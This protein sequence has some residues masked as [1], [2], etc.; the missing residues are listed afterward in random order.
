MNSYQMTTTGSSDPLQSMVS[1]QMHRARMPL[2]HIS[3]VFT[4]SASSLCTIISCLHQILLAQRLDCR[5]NHLTSDGLKTT[6][7]DEKT[8]LPTFISYFFHFFFKP[9]LFP[10]F[11]N[12][13]RIAS[14][15]DLRICALLYYTKWI[16]TKHQRARTKKRK[17][18]KRFR[19]NLKNYFGY[20]V[21]NFFML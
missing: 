20:I 1:I 16:C 2:V 12:R 10:L 7:N 19:K 15:A 8:C 11:R 4:T 21:R 13:T 18:K 3:C 9:M 6:L 17:E 5:T 14:R